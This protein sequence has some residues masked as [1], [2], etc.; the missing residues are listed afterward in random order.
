MHASKA[1]PSG[2]RW[3]GP[4]GARRFQDPF[5]GEPIVANDILRQLGHHR[6]ANGH[7]V[8][9]DHLPCALVAAVPIIR[10][11]LVP[12]D[13][14]TLVQAQV[15]TTSRHELS[16]RRTCF[17]G[18]ELDE[19]TGL[20]YFGARYYDPRTNL[21]AATDPPSRAI[22]TSWRRSPENLALYNYE[23]RS[24][25]STLMVATSSSR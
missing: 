14:G 20:Y 4:R 17:T 5:T 9:V 22:R 2:A 15:E 25:P 13:T 12:T 7:N 18:K 21:F 1:A 3:C 23:P 24:Y 11:I 19:E 16:A 8:L 10:L 6:Y